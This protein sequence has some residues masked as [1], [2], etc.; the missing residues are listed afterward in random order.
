M[1]LKLFRSNALSSKILLISNSMTYFIFQSSL[2]PFQATNQALQMQVL[3][4]CERQ[5]LHSLLVF[6]K[7]TLR[8]LSGSKVQSCSVEKGSKRT[9]CCGICLALLGLQEFTSPF[10]S[11]T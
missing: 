3:S 6:S 9:S 1:L 5:L 7:L 11:K 10:L 4:S 2:W 8:C